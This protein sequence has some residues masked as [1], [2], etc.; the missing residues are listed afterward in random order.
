M[1]H[2]KQADPRVHAA[3]RALAAEV[4]ELGLHYNV[5][6]YWRAM[7]DMVCSCCHRVYMQCLTCPSLQYANLHAI[8]FD[9][10]SSKGNKNARH[11]TAPDWV[12]GVPANSINHEFKTETQRAA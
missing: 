8:G 7:Y 1:P 6:T 3:V 4:P 2:H 9:H 12:K 5:T 10:G 11:P